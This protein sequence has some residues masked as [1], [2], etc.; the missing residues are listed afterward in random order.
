VSWA[1]LPPE[2]REL[3]ERV[4]TRKELEALKL[5]DAGA[6]YRRVALMLGISPSS[7]RDRIVRAVRKLAAATP[8]RR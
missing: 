7:A 6:G 8:S 5:W 2:V 4:C 3:A 1:T